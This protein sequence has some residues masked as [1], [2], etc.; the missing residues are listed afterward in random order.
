MKIPFGK[1]IFT[2]KDYKDVVNTLK[3]GILVHGKKNHE[4]ENLFQKFTKS[5]YAISVSSCTAGLFLLYYV[6]GI[7]KNDEIIV[8]SQTH[9]ATALSFSAL[10]AKPIFVDSEPKTGNIDFSKIKKLITK[11]TKAISIVHYLGFAAE[12]KKIAKIAKENNL[13]LIEDCALALGTKVNNKHVGLFG[14]AGVFSFYPIKHITTAE[15]GMIITN[16]GK[17]ARKLILSKS[18]GVNKQFSDRKIS[19][20]YDVVYPGLNL[21]M[22]ELSSCLGINQIKNFKNFKTIRIKNYNKYLKIFQK[23]N[24]FDVVR[25]S[26]KNEDWSYYAFPLIL[27]KKYKFK[28]NQ[29]VSYLKKRNIGT[30]V[31]YPHPLPRLSYFKNKY[32]V[33]LNR[34][35]NAKKFSDQTI[36]LPI[37]PHIDD[38]KI[39]TISKEIFSFIKSIK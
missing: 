34:F 7:K 21:R 5:K 9:A 33:N 8:S 26:K 19:G 27:N 17:L 18:L 23:R 20:I 39:S 10:G 32:K 4:F 14:D 11:K 1:P 24:E 16:N 2:K 15:G 31:Y 25:K 36:M 30:S 3:S 37:G 22:N 35:P 6:L 12:I 13:F 38:K 29:L 28:R